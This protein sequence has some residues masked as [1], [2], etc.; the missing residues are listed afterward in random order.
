MYN[1]TCTPFYI[2]IKGTGTT[3]YLPI[4]GTGANTCLPIIRTC[5]PTYLHVIG[6]CTPTYIPIIG[7]CTLVEGM[8]SAMSSMNTE[9]ANSIVRPRLIFS[10]ESGF[11]QKQSRV[12][13]DN[14]THGMMM[15]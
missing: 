5:T 1:K 12:N 4:K 7:T 14:I 8:F 9:K 3:T 10:P 2:P 13:I 15:L 6:T 11:I